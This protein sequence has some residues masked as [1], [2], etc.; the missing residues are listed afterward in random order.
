MCLPNENGVIVHL[1]SEIVMFWINSIDDILHAAILE[2]PT[3]SP[4]T[5]FCCFY[6]WS[7]QSFT[8]FSN[9]H[10][11]LQC[12]FFIIWPITFFFLTLVAYNFLLS[13]FQATIVSCSDW[14]YRIFA[15]LSSE[16][17]SLNKCCH[18]ILPN[19]FIYISRSTVILSGW[20]DITSQYTLLLT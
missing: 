3:S 20:F 15:I 16:T 13:F 7:F 2:P 9:H 17:T 14:Q 6:Q 1:S 10:S 12:F 18:H 11:V 4:S 19:L 8:V 5:K